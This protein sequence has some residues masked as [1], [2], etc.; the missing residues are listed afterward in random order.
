MLIYCQHEREN[1]ENTN[2][3]FGG[4]LTES[5]RSESEAGFGYF[6]HKSNGTTSSGHGAV[7]GVT[8]CKNP[9]RLA[10]I[11]A[12]KNGQGTDLNGRVPPILIAGTPADQLAIQYGE[13]SDSITISKR[14]KR[15]YEKYSNMVGNLDDVGNKKIR[16]SSDTVGC[17]G[18]LALSGE[19]FELV[20][21]SSSG[22][23]ILKKNGRVGSAPAVGAGFAA[24]GNNAA[25]CSGTGEQIVL[26]G[27]AF[28][29]YITLHQSCIS[30][31]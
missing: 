13:S 8:K 28:G 30:L 7:S 15:S 11:L 14:S 31:L 3:G 26:H 18:G 4:N 20:A 2:A 25:T 10:R 1:S 27:T 16:L 19:E 12:E 6:S 23:L 24:V 22:G 29:L 17:V 5:G 21:G 9:I